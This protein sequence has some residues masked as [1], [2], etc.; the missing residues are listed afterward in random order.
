M[1]LH[2]DWKEFIELLNAHRV[3]YVV[4]GAYA[5]SFYTTPRN[6]ADI[7]FL[8]RQNEENAARV[9]SALSEFGI[10]LSDAEAA[11]FALPNHMIQLGV[12]PYRIDIL[13]SIGGPETDGILDR[14]QAGTLGGLSVRFP[15]KEDLIAAKEAVGRPKDLADLARLTGRQTK[16]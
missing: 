6:T 16:R 5:V 8:V 7:D 13:T 14:A 12:A 11:K 3:D 1:D 15:S 10:R 4:V 2:P 9:R